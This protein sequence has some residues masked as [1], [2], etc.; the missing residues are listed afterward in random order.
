MPP[1]NEQLSLFNTNMLIAGG[2]LKSEQSQVI[3]NFVVQV[4][5]GDQSQAKLTLGHGTGLW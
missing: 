4:I 3:S 1:S 5:Q 2:K